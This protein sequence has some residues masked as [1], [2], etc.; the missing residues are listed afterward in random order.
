MVKTLDIA[1]SIPGF[2]VV[3]SV[4]VVLFTCVP[5]SPVQFGKGQWQL[6]AWE[7]PMVIVLV[8]QALCL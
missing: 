8:S 7:E 3:M 6:A 1:G 5:L 2:F 4:I